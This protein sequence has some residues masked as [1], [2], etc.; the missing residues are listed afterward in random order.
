MGGMLITISMYAKGEVLK[1]IRLY[2][3]GRG[4]VKIMD[5]LQKLTEFIIME[6]LSFNIITLVSS[7]I[8]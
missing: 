2:N 7:E 1:C 6:H 5:D 4:G 3:R 8:F